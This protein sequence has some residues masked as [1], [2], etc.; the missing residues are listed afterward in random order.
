M[1]CGSAPAKFGVLHCD[2][3]WTGGGT[4]KEGQVEGYGVR[5]VLGRKGCAKVQ[6]SCREDAG[7]HKAAMGNCKSG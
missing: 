7:C 3:Y 2:S 1:N 5:L 4:P 6:A